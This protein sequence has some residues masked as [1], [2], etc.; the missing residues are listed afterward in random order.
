MKITSTWTEQ[1]FS[2]RAQYEDFKS[3]LKHCLP[4]VI[5]NVAYEGYKVIIPDEECIVVEY[6]SYDYRADNMLADII[7]EAREIVE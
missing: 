5:K 1:D 7:D 6:D 3:S 2:N 4:H